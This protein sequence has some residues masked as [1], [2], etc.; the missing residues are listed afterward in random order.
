MKPLYPDGLP[1]GEPA[2][3]PKPMDV[4]GYPGDKLHCVCN[5]RPEL[6]TKTPTPEEWLWVQ[7]LPG[8]PI[9]PA[10]LKCVKGYKGK[11]VCKVK[12]DSNAVVAQ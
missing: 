6:K 9:D 1:W 12:E 7:S 4:G 3:I 5:Q 2:L 8:V 11:Q 10:T